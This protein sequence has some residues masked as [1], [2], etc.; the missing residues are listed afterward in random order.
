MKAALAKKNL[1]E[2]LTFFS[3]VVNDNYS[4][5]PATTISFR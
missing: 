5:P 2:A 1:A 4:F 3:S